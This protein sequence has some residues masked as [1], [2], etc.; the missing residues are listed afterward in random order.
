MDSKK[1]QLVSL[2]S[3]KCQQLHWSASRNS[4]CSNWREVEKKEDNEIDGGI[5]PKS[6]LEWM[7]LHK[8]LVNWDGEL[9][10]M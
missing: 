7:S 3:N 9:L 1:N 4:T 2:G 10:F 5:G 8:L 6:L